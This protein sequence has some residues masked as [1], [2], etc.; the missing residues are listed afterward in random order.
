M[1]HRF[2]ASHKRKILNLIKNSRLTTF[3]VGSNTQ[4]VATYRHGLKMV[5]SDLQ[6]DFFRIQKVPNLFFRYFGQFH[7]EK[8]FRN[9]VFHGCGR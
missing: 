6:I 3:A 7:V 9:H 4:G 8:C 1:F 5:I 2:L